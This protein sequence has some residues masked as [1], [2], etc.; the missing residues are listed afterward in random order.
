MPDRATA[1]FPNATYDPSHPDSKPLFG[2]SP[3]SRQVVVFHI[4]VRYSHPLGLLAPG[5]LEFRARLA[6]QY[7][8]LAL[9]AR[10]YGFLGGSFWRGAE[11]SRVN[12]GM[13]VMYFASLEGLHAFAHD[14]V[15]RGAWEWYEGFVR[16]TGHRHIGIF[17]ETFVVPAGRWETIYGNCPPV[18]MAG[19]SVPVVDEG[20]GE[21]EW[22]RPVVD[23]ATPRLRSK[24]GRMGKTQGGYQL[25]E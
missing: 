10:E 12:A 4:G 23:G 18:L 16:R 15:H 5:V 24:Y 11:R 17:H 2:S 7:D 9:R 13:A 25:G 21:E 3:S 20:N 6:A 8:E 1:Q 22:V 14:E 19:T